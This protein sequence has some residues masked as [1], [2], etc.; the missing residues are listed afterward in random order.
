MRQQSKCYRNTHTWP[1]AVCQPINRGHYFSVLFDCL[2]IKMSWIGGAKKY[3]ACRATGQKGSRCLRGL[4]LQGAAPAAQSPPSSPE[5]LWPGL[6]PLPGSWGC[7]QCQQELLT[8]DKL[9]LRDCA[10]QPE[11]APA[12]HLPQHPHLS[13]CSTEEIW[14][15]GKKKKKRYLKKTDYLEKSV[16]AQISPTRVS[17][18]L[19]EVTR[20]NLSWSTLVW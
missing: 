11:V 20:D 5:P 18:V 4:S 8:W 10:R 2:Q 9:T 13:F 16:P 15:S 14:L 3:N 17:P 1:E 12:S 19:W 6:Q 7:L